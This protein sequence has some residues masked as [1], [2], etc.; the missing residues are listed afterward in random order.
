MCPNDKYYKL[1]LLY[2]DVNTTLLLNI[3]WWPMRTLDF[4]RVTP[5]FSDGIELWPTRNKFLAREKTRARMHDIRTEFLGRVSRTSF[6]DRELGSSVMGFSQNWQDSHPYVCLPAM[7]YCRNL[8]EHQPYI[9]LASSTSYWAYDSFIYYQIFVTFIARN[10][11]NKP[12][13][14]Q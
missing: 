12:S 11:Q 7:Q 2:T 1:L 5:S 8:R 9:K 13:P 4:S 10:S 14:Q 3:T 6:L